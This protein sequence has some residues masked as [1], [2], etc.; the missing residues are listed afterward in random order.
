MFV[1]L[2][3]FDLTHDSWVGLGF[4][5]GFFVGIPWWSGVCWHTK[6][7]VGSGW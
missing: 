2:F 5:F 6:G 3:V 7:P 4:G 1:E